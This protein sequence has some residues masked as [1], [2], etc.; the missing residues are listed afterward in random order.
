[1]VQSDLIKEKTEAEKAR[2][3][4]KWAGYVTIGPQCVTGRSGGVTSKP[5]I[6]HNIPIVLMRYV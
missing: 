4:Y 1:M 6:S 3:R 5:K 2:P